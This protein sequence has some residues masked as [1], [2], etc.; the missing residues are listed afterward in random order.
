MFN[1]RLFPLLLILILQFSV[2]TVHCRLCYLTGKVRLPKDVNPP[3]DDAL[4]V[5]DDF[6]KY[7]RPPIQQHK[8]LH[9]QLQKFSSYPAGFALASFSAG[10]A[11]TTE[12]IVTAGKLYSAA[13]A[14]LLDRGEKKIQNQLQ[15]VDLFI[16]SQIEATKGPDGRDSTIGILNKLIK[17]CGPNCTSAEIAKIQD[18]IAAMSTV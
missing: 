4:F 6:C 3:S 11:H 18:M 5:D 8:I 16:A 10:G 1:L 2:Y 14:A 9:D 15:V 7:S 12:S 13:N 17:I